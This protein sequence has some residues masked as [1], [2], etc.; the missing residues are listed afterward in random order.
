MACGREGCGMAIGRVWKVGPPFQQPSQATLV[1]VPESLDVVG[2]HLVNDQLRHQPRR[3]VP[4]WADKRR[5]KP[6]DRQ[7]RQEREPPG[8]CRHSSLSPTAAAACKSAAASPAWDARTLRSTFPT[9]CWMTFSRATQQ[10]MPA[11][12]SSDRIT[13]AST[14][15][16]W[17][18]EEKTVT[19]GSSETG[20]CISLRAVYQTALFL[21]PRKT[22]PDQ[23]CRILESANAAR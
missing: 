17:L 2:A 11:D 4:G 8:Q 15:A 19:R 21:R 20:G 22:L 3:M 6:E 14:F 1:Q 12:S 9:G 23:P 16:R 13:S 7:K 10:K 5:A 18:R